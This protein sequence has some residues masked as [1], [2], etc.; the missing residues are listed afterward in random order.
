[1]LFPLVFYAEHNERAPRPAATQPMERQERVPNIHRVIAGAVERQAIRL[2]LSK[3]VFRQSW[4]RPS[5]Q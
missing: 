2:P 5:E 3:K 1:M 4:H